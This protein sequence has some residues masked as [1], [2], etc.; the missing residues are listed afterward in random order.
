MNE[1]K[2]KKFK[3]WTKDHA[4]DLAV[5]TVLLAFT[6]GFTA[7]VVYAI[8]EDNKRIDAEI[9]ELQEQEARVKAIRTAVIDEHNS[10]NSVYTLMDGTYLS[11][12][13][14]ANPKLITW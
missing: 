3:R 11:V 7:L 14:N 12:P 4:E 2:M 10:G 1:T 5:G 6:G 13:A 9:A 8:K